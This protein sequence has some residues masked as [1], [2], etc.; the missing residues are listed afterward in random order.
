MTSGSA[1]R[2]RE[3]QAGERDIETASH[4]TVATASDRAELRALR[5]KVAALRAQLRAANQERAVLR[6]QLAAVDTRSKGSGSDHAE[7]D[8]A[9][10]SGSWDPAEALPPGILIPRWS[11]S[12]ARGFR[13]VPADVAGDALRTV[14]QLAAADGATWRAVKRSK[15]VIKTVL[16]VRIGS[17]RLIFGI[18]D[19]DLQVVKLVRSGALEMALKRLRDA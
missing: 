16:M 19:N 5:G 7:P 1:T 6:R 12:A 4:A 9:D 18:Q 14:A 2:P 3:H 10:E 8:L 15:T 13:D 17:Y 11:R